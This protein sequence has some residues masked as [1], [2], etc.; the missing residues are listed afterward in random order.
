M[1]I[2]WYTS[3]KQTPI[4]L[5]KKQSLKKK[6]HLSSK[7]KKEVEAIKNARIKN[8]KLGEFVY[9]IDDKE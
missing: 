5:T 7:E 3:N 4:I 6:K 9:I 1:K 2:M 8:S